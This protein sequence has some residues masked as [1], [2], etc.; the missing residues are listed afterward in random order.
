MKKCGVLDSATMTLVTVFGAAHLLGCG[1]PAAAPAGSSSEALAALVA[2]GLDDGTIE[3]GGHLG[4]CDPGDA[5]KTTIC[6]IPPGNPANAHTICVGN[7]AVPH[8]VKNH[9]D[10]VGP[11]RT[12]TS[13]PTPPPPCGDSHDHGKAAA[14]GGGGGAC[15]AGHDGQ[16]PAPTCPDGRAACGVDPAA[17]PADVGTCTNGCCV[18]W[19]PL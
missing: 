7:P 2:C 1:A 5:K 18:A 15:D 13:C 16:T 12:E 14:G 11:C 17:C 10:L 6:H 8:H 3:P 4:A 19:I 9:G